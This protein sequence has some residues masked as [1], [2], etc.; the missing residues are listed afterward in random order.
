MVEEIRF[1]WDHLDVVPLAQTERILTADTRQAEI[2]RLVPRQ[3]RLHPPQRLRPAGPHAQVH[4]GGEG[5]AAQ[6]DRMRKAGN[7]H[8]DS[9]H[10]FSDER[11]LEIFKNPDTVYHSTAG[12]ER[13]IFR[14]GEDIA[15]AEGRIPAKNGYMAPGVQIR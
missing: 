2:D 1:T 7:H 4:E 8:A 13:L 3:Q 10:G 6:G 15:V 5:P 14:Q 12:S 11:V 9:M